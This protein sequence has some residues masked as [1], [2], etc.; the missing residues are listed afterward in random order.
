MSGQVLAKIVAQTRSD[1]AKRKSA[2]S[3]EAVAEGLSPSPRDFAESLRHRPGAPGLI[4][5]LKLRSPSRGEIR[6]GATPEQ[7]IPMYA[8][9]ASAISVL[10]DVPFFGGGF[11]KLARARTLCDRPLLCKDFIVDRYQIAEA[12]AAGAD[13]VLLM[14]SVLN[15]AEMADLLNYT[16]TL[17]MEALV[18]T[19]DDDEL[20]RAL[21]VGAVVVGVNSR[22]LRT[23][24]IDFERMLERLARVPGGAVRVAESGVE[25]RAQV[26]QLL[27]LAD[28]ALVG[29]QLMS[30]PDPEAAIKE[31]GWTRK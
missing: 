22:D 19:H 23:L 20:A 16:R 28:V 13:A 31:L 25:T 3:F 12:R 30:S 24:T 10:C 8:P 15:D 26:E 7:I 11:D 14:A 4:A 29:S 6:P 27:G 2:R 21:N 17:G 9:Y 18:E 1:L 5:E